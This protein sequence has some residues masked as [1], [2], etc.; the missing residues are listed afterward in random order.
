M[1]SNISGKQPLPRPLWV[2]FAGTFVNRFGSFVNIFLVLYM[3]S[4]G[5]SAAQAGT[6]AGAYGIGSVIA[7]P[8]GGYCA[9]RLG[10]RN[11]IMLSMFS[12]AATMLLLSQATALPLLLLLVV[13]AGLTTELYRPASGALIADLAPSQQRVRAFALYEFAINLG[14]IVGP[15]VAGLL[16]SHS[17]LLLFIGDALTSVIFGLLALFVLPF[18]AHRQEEPS[19][20][21]GGSVRVILRDRSF[22]LFLLA[23]TLVALVYLQYLAALPLQMRALGLSTNIYGLLISL[24]G[25]VTVV[26]GLPLSVLTQRFPRK[27]TIAVGFLLTGVGFGLV[28]FAPTVPLLVLTVIIWTLGEMIHSPVSPAYVADLAPPHLRGR[29]QGAWDMTWGIGLILAPLL[30]TVLFS[31]SASGVWFLCG[32]LGVIA[33]ALVLR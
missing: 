33:A 5:Y 7:S 23:T 13:L 18:E 26:L 12:S 6:A 16:A 32:L 27:I 2:L 1:F 21:Q 25:L 14:V 15:A 31:W 3:I 4:R 19:Q 10:R 30:G 29:Y 28:A 9:D 17:F 24:N 11:T 22:L 8:L 20:E